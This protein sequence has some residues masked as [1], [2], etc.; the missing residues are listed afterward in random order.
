MLFDDIVTNFETLVTLC[1]AVEHLVLPWNYCT[2]DGTSRHPSVKWLDTW[3]P[4]LYDGGGP[5]PEPDDDPDHVEIDPLRFSN[6]A[7]HRLL[8]PAL[9]AHVEDLPRAVDPGVPGTWAITYPGLAI[10]Q[11]GEQTPGGRARLF[12]AME[13]NV[14]EREQQ[15]ADLGNGRIRHEVQPEFHGPYRRPDRYSVKPHVPFGMRDLQPKVHKVPQA[16]PGVPRYRADADD[17]EMETEYLADLTDE[18]Y[19]KEME[20]YEKEAEAEERKAR[21]RQAVR[22]WISSLPAIPTRDSFPWLSGALRDSVFSYQS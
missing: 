4:R 6:L 17:S 7:G 12:G 20:F 8:D 22:D 21:Q 1:P 14:V 18:F 11:E 16:V 9:L 3:L 5:Y 2:R 13:V 19:G 15:Y 10:E